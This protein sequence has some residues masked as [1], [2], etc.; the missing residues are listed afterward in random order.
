VKDDGTTTTHAVFVDA[1][2]SA[3]WYLIVATTT[4][5]GTQVVRVVEDGDV[6]IGRAASSDIPIDHD[7][8]SRRHAIV[9]RRADRVTIEDLGS[10]NGTLVNGAAIEGVRRL[11]AGDAIAIGPMTAVVAISSAA[12]SSRQIATI[13]ELEDRLESEVD[14]AHRYHRSLALVMARFYGNADAITTHIER[15]GVQLRRMDLLAEYSVDEIAIVLPE[16]DRAAAEIVA[17]RV[18]QA[19]GLR[20]H[21]GIAAFPAD[22]SSS[23]ELISAARD[24]LRG[25]RRASTAKPS[26]ASELGDDVVISDPQMKQLFELAKRVAASTI[27]VLIAGETGAGK[28]VV[29]GAIHRLGPR[30][31]GPYVRLN[32]AS[33]P[34]SLV[35]TELFGHEKGAFTGASS[36]KRGFFESAAGGTLFLD[37]IGELPAS[38]QAKLLRVIENRTITRVGGTQEIEVDVRLICASNRDLE[39]EVR[40]GR[41]REDLYFRISA[42]V[43]PV[44]PLRDRP[45]EI[46][47]LATQFARDLSADAGGTGSIDDAAM[48]ILRSYDW[49]GNVRELRN[50]IERATVMC[51]HGRIEPSHLPERVRERSTRGLAGAAALGPLDVRQRVAVV[52]RDAVIQALEANKGNQTHAAR[53]LGVSRFALIRL[54]E[55]HDLKSR[56]R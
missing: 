10:R 3:S 12:R 13:G 46:P 23:G 34:E 6:V 8:V 41:F 53:Q 19:G 55:K 2:P 20:I 44:P 38:M 39:A 36:L 49:P 31:A 26:L 35:E 30:T 17:A 15:L 43:I 1:T 22:G 7:A 48:A 47:L 9:R 29:A 14:R 27:T 37:E 16:S 25:M 42:F 21:V 11:T 56:P 33:L 5:V 32:C 28:E 51:G 18:G 24:R 40:R 45:S 52:E 4:A 50:V 54:M